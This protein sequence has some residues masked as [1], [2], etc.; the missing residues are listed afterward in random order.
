MC[1]LSYTLLLTQVVKHSE[2][3]EQLAKELTTNPKGF[4]SVISYAGAIVFAFFIPAVSDVLIILVALMW[5][6]PDRRIEKYI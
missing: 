6:I 4:I 3:H 2:N 5:F 1:A